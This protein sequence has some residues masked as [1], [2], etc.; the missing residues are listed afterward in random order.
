VLSH[1]DDEREISAITTYHA[2]LRPD[3]FVRR[4]L[5]RVAKRAPREACDVGAGIGRHSILLA[6]LGYRVLAIEHDRETASRLRRLARE[7][8]LPIRVA[9]SDAT[10]VRFRR[11]L[12]FVCVTNLL[13]HLGRDAGRRLIARLRDATAV[14]G[15]HVVTVFTDRR[16]QQAVRSPFRPGQ[17]RAMYRDWDIL[18]YREWTTRPL[19]F[20]GPVA[21]R[22]PYAAVIARRRDIPKTATGSLRRRKNAGP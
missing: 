18:E 9:G 13:H 15:V 6:V 2:N 11:G 22:F 8:D 14:G 12:G 4:G 16:P 21:V 20:G 5:D 10:A 1:A 3:G 7:L 19:R 17:L